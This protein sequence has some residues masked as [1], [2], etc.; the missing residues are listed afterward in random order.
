MQILSIVLGFV[1]MFIVI[2]FLS[3]DQSTYGIYTVCIS[4]TI[5]LSYA[6]LGFLGAA[7]KYAAESYARN[8]IHQEASLLGFSHFILFIITLLIGGVFL[9]LSFHPEYLISNLQDGYQTD[10]AQ[11]LLLILA[12]FTPTI[13]LQRLAQMI[14]GIRLQEYN[15]QRLVIIGNITKI[16]SVFY[17]FTNKKYDIAGYYL[18]TQII[19]TGISLISLL[20]AKI[21]FNY[22]LQ[23][24][25]SKFRFSYEIFNK[26]RTLA[27]S[28]LYVTICWVLYYELDSI[29]IAKLLGA[30]SVAIYAIGLSMLSFVRS[31]FGVIFSPF[32]SRFNHFIGQ[33]LLTELRTFYFTVIKMTC[34]LIIFPLVAIA[35]MS[36]A[37]VVSWV[38]W[39]Y[40]ASGEIVI[41]LMLCNILAFISYPAG[42]MLVAQE[43]IKQ[44][45][46][47]NALMVLTFWAGIALTVHIWGVASFARFKFLSFILT[48]ISYLF[49]SLKFL[50][51]SIGHFLRKV[52]LPYL[53]GLIFVIMFTY[54]VHDTC[55]D[56]KNKLNLFYN[57]C[58]LV[59]GIGGGLLISLFCASEL[60]Q[61][62]E[63]I[64]SAFRS[65]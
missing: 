53:P 55:M 40:S 41:W 22:P 51:I 29:A 13:V 50:Q 49:F 21:R 7:Q 31:L 44:M 33:G 14:F 25:L 24:L 28:S 1:S 5:F 15:I 34:P 65:K 62:V 37:I 56:G 64:I 12:T 6:D 3:S 61:Q 48:G 2:P 27:F 35:I 43:K 20:H 17:F 47:I 11:K 9:Y 52:I 16:V 23:L 58:L 38:G 18:F 4:V 36:E 32:S 63:K 54:L 46:W 57:G 45:Y 39:E 8:D 60:K 59:C 42:V 30:N 10:I 26:T 19:T